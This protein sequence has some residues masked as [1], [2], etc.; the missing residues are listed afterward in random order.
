M[1]AD[2][3]QDVSRR[4]PC[5]ICGK[6]DWCS[7]AI[8]GS[9]YA[10][11]RRVFEGAVRIK[12]DRNGGEFAVHRLSESV[13]HLLKRLRPS[14]RNAPCAIP[15]MRD[16]VYSRVLAL[17]QLRSQ[18][19]DNLNVRGLSDREIEHRRYRSTPVGSVVWD[20]GDAIVRE[21]GLDVCKTIP[22]LSA[23]RVLSSTMCRI[24][25]GAGL[26]IPVRNLQGGIVA[27][28]VRLDD[29][30]DGG[31]YRY[32]TSSGEGGPSPGQQV[33]VPLFPKHFDGI[34]RLTEGELKADVA[35]ARSGVWTI[36]IPGVQSWSLA[37]PVLKEMQA[38]TV[39]LAFDA[40]AK[41][42]RVVARALVMAA[43]ALEEEGFQTEME[44]W[45]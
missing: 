41:T 24:V 32:V 25:C 6:P 33:H 43:K 30:A 15:E 26:L 3:W 37:V 19:K 10:I 21:F 44:Q 11:C 40:D 38:R 29:P 5:P 23:K 27:L 12:M 28:K 2:A 16:K 14:K 4:Q 34:V 8:D 22:G 36:S 13:P 42:N 7:V 35:S 9:P 31:K 18:H 20:I 1:S 39:V 45:S 17:L